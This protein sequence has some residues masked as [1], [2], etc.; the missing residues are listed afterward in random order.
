[1]YHAK[2]RPPQAES[3][4]IERAIGVARETGGRLFIVHMSTDRGMD[5]VASARA[6][7]LEVFAETCTHYLVF[8]EEMY[9]RSDGIKWVC[10]PALRS[11]SIQDEL[12]KGLR[13]RRISMVTSDDAAYSW[14]AKQFGKDRFDR[15]A[16]LTAP[17]C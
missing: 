9:A 3:M 11:R 13:D 4:A 7:G 17:V 2:S 15:R 14:E 1:M 6:E 16:D 5:M 10:S 12:W 8:T